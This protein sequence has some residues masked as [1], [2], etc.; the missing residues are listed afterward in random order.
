MA[1]LQ[2]M[3][4]ALLTQRGHLF[5]WVPVCF[6]M[7][8]G[9]YFLLK[10]EPVLACYAWI[11]LLV[12]PGLWLARRSGGGWGPVVWAVL[13]F[14]IGFSV[15][16]LRAHSMAAPVLGWRYYGPVAWT[17]LCCATSPRNRHRNG[18]AWP[19]MAISTSPHHGQG[20]R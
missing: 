9:C 13:L 11:L 1:L 4:L 7:G 16:G 19:C 18:C 17:G 14:A 12:L 20:R 8:I 3:E 15:A 2:R 5:P 10:Q 6:A